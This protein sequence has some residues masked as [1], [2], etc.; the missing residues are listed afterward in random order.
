MKKS[1]Q[2]KISKLL[3]KIIIFALFFVCFELTSVLAVEPVDI[4]KI[5][6]IVN[7]KN[8]KEV[9][10]EIKNRD[11]LNQK[12]N[13]GNKIED[14]IIDKNLDTQNIKLAG[15]YDPAEN[16]LSIDMWSNSDG[17]EIKNLMNKIN[18]KKL[19]YFSEKI[20]NIALLTNSYI[21]ENNISANEFLNFKFDYLKN[22][23]DFELI[24]NFL[25]KNLLLKNTD[26]LVN[27]YA[28]HYLSNS[29][30]DKACEIFDVVNFVSDDYLTNFKIYCLIDKDRKDEAQLLF[31]LKSEIVSIEEFFNKKFNVL[32][33][34]EDEDETVLD[35]NILNFH[36]SHRTNKNFEY[37]PELNT[38]RFIW[39]YLS[40]SNLLKDTDLI[41]IE[42]SDQVKLVEKAT[43]ADVY[44]EKELLDL[45]KRFQFD[46]NQFIN[47]N[48][49]YKLLP[50]YKSRALLYQR[51]LLTIDVNQKLILLSKLKDSFNNSN[52]ENAFNT[53]LENFL[54]NID[55]KD[56]PSNFT[57]F[58]LNNVKSDDIVKSKIKFNNKLVHQSKLLN[59]FLNKTS[60]TKVE[61]EA[62]DL[63]KKIKKNKNYFF[64]R[65][66]ILILESLKSDGVQISKKYENMYESNTEIPSEINSMILNGE[67]GLVLLKLV[68]IIG[69]DELE[70][71]DIESIYY[72]VTILNEIQLI[73]L[74]NEVLLKVLPLKV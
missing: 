68:E 71:L 57:T 31:D 15:L 39:E 28:N 64:S 4:W 20:L 22:K 73:D 48:D 12:I 14:I 72:I 24:K 30:L 8:E 33:G 61:K 60:L 26:D 45:Y 51:L 40:T 11:I 70:N 74:R 59:Y 63:L 7:L 42:N 66:D 17:G 52:L 53:E 6:K 67:I 43:N 34:Y 1:Y 56:I 23:K 50:D 58:Y 16:G 13:V 25:S 38:P 19:S 37:E 44:N 65:K 49:S 2:M 62:N 32:M 47:I 35:D 41:D 10:K 54:K 5:E 55:K 18:V 69:E 9:K 46:I 36:L 3:N 29:K 21:P 27:F